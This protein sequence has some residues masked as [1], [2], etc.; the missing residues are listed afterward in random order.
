MSRPAAAERERRARVITAD[1][2][3]QAAQQLSNASRMVA[4]T[5]ETMQL[6]LLQSVV[7]V[8][9]EKH[10]TPVMPF[11]VLRSFDRAARQF[12][13]GS[14]VATPD[15]APHDETVTDPRA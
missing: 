1:G 2:E 7:E 6:R 15:P 12:G 10:S 5:P 9:A 14:D 3:F 11:P 8:A 4:D 13:T